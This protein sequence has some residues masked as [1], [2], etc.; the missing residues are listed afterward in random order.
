MQMGKGWSTYVI[1]SHKSSEQEGGYHYNG[2][3]E[4]LYFI[5]APDVSHSSFLPITPL[6]YV[7]I[8]AEVLS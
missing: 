2:G 3:S 4:L 5:I 6:H 8:H 1:G 7:Y